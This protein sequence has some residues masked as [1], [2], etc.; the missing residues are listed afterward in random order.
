[1]IRTIHGTRASASIDNFTLWACEG[2]DRCGMAER[3][4]LRIRKS[5]IS[6]QRFSFRKMTDLR[7]E[8]AFFHVKIRLHDRRVKTSS[9]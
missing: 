9:F 5:S 1:M 6:K 7:E 3:A 8:N 4:R 2:V